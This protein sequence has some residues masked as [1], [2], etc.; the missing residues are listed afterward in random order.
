MYID[1]ANKEQVDAYFD[2]VVAPYFNE[3][4]S[5]EL[6]RDLSL[7]KQRRAFHSLCAKTATQPCTMK[8][9]VYQIETEEAQSVYDRMCWFLR[10][11]AKWTQHQIKLCSVILE[12]MA[13]TA[14]NNRHRSFF[15]PGEVASEKHSKF[16]L[17]EV[18]RFFIPVAELRKLPGVGKIA[19]KLDSLQQTGLLIRSIDYVSPLDWSV[20]RKGGESR[21]KEWRLFIPVSGKMAKESTFKGLEELPE[22]EQVDKVQALGWKSFCAGAVNLPSWCAEE[23]GFPRDLV[24]EDQEVAKTFGSLG[25]SLGLMRPLEGSGWGR[26]LYSETL[27]LR[28]RWEPAEYTSP[29]QANGP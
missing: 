22:E 13:Q 12:A 23:A 6:S 1:P 29:K 26:C 8:A 28:F 20:V 10:C 19:K 16:D 21:C 5:G 11:H 25:K 2:A 27:D 15:C 9:K 4:V 3:R 17:T 14:V 7:K 18:F 24:T